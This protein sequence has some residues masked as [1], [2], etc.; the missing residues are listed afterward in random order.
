M[1][2][3]TC[4]HCQENVNDALPEFVECRQM[5]GNHWQLDVALFIIFYGVLTA[6]YFLKLC[7]KTEV[8]S[9]IFVLFLLFSVIYGFGASYLSI[10]NHFEK[11]KQECLAVVGEPWLCACPLSQMN[12]EYYGGVSSK[13]CVDYC[14]NFETQTTCRDWTVSQ[15][16]DQVF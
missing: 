13:A 6:I 9:Y 12:L 7:P 16:F 2:I 8:C 11:S 14:L 15:S 10:K 1:R 4:K 3:L 5:F